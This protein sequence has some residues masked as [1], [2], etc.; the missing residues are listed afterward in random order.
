MNESYHDQKPNVNDKR[1]VGTEEAARDFLKVARSRERIVK[2]LL[3][4]F[5]SHPNRPRTKVI[6]RLIRRLNK[7]AQKPINHISRATIYN[8]LRDYS[9]G[10]AGALIPKWRPGYFSKTTENEKECLIDIL[11]SRITH[12]IGTAI[13]IAKYFLKRNGIPSPSSPATLRR[14]VERYLKERRE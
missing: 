3:K 14:W 12:R 10:G 8:W 13:L 5:S 6:Q 9:K 11:N 1:L 7:K 4:S 2:S